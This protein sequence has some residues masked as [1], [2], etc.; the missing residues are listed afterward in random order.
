MGE[1]TIPKKVTNRR[2]TSQKEL[3]LL[4]FGIWTPKTYL[5]HQTSGGIW[6]SWDTIWRISYPMFHQIFC[7]PTVITGCLNHQQKERHCVEIGRSKSFHVVNCHEVAV[8]MFHDLWD[9]FFGILPHH[10]PEIF[11]RFLCWVCLWD[12]YR[13]LQ[14][15]LDYPPQIPPSI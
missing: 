6:M 5:K 13:F 9:I 15:D 2:I 14:P 3:T 12:F 11:V 7:I 1:L 4:R 8:W 10:R